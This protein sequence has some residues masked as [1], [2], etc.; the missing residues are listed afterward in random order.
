MAVRPCA[1]FRKRCSEWAAAA[2]ARTLPC[3]VSWKRRAFSSASAAAS[4]NP[5]RSPRSASEN[6][7]SGLDASDRAPS[8]SPCAM[9]G[10]ATTDVCP[11]PAASSRSHAGRLRRRSFVTS[12][13]ETGRRSL[14]AS[15]ATLD[16]GGMARPFHLSPSDSPAVATQTRL[17]EAG[18]NSKKQARSPRKWSSTAVTTRSLAWARLRV[19][20]SSW[21]TRASALAASS[22]CFRSVMSRTIMSS[23]GS[24]PPPGGSGRS[25]AS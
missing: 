1:S 15:A 9:R 4:A 17:P 12:R 21:P 24:A 13:E 25:R 5:E 11:S 16:P 6:T 22:A 18:S 19:P 2:W 20:T 3:S 7:R 10:T 8:T 23:C 14:T